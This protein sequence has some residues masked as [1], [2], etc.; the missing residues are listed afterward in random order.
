MNKYSSHPLHALWNL[1][2]APMQVQALQ[3][4]LKQ[5]L[6]DQLTQP[7]SA[8]TVARSLKL[9]AETVAIWLDMLWSMGLLHRHMGLNNAAPEYV[10]TELAAQF[11][12]EFSKQN[13]AAAWQVRA[14]FL[15]EFAQQWE[16]LLREGRQT[17]DAAQNSLLQQ[18]WAQAAREHLGQE[19]RVVSAPAVLSLLDR[20]PPLPQK[21]CF[22]D[23]GGGPGHVAVALAQRLPGWQG[24]VVEQAHTADVAQETINA[25]KLGARLSIKECDLNTGMGIGSGYDLIWCS[26]VLHFLHD[27]QAAVQNLYAA[28]NPGGRLLLAHAEL[29]D[30]PA[31]A[32]LILPFYAG[33]MLRGGHLPRSGEISGWMQHAGFTNIRA[34]GRIPWALAPIW[35]HTGH[36][37]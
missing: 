29:S 9:N 21:G 11:F 31:Q 8:A 4:A 33:V 1:A 14:D 15:A 6:F 22:A 27:P 2:A 7:A 3:Q 12:S 17:A 19:Q 23:V 28:L 30:D 34:L 16:P 5:R 13:C 20:L 18:R 10:A 25:A 36:H 24:V 26:S 32:A 37:A 35:V